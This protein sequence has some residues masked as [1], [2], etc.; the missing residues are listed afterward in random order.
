MMRKIAV[1]EHSKIFMDIAMLKARYN[2]VGK[3]R[4]R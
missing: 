4:R 2:G 1:N 3:R